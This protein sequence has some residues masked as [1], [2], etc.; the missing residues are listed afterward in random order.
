MDSTEVFLGALHA[1]HA[2]LNNKARTL[3]FIFKITD[4]TEIN[5]KNFISRAGLEVIT[6]S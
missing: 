6:V 5:S 3:L 1:S 4:A 2:M